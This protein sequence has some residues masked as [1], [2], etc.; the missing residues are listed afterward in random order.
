MELFSL[1]S[2]YL[3][4]GYVFVAGLALGWLFWH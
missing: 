4:F 1:L 2:A 3:Q